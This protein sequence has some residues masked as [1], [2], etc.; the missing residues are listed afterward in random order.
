MNSVETRFAHLLQPIRDLTKNWDVD[1]ATQ[2]GEYLE[3]LDQMTISFDGGKTMMNFAE[4]A[5]LIQGSTCIY[6]RKVELLHSLVFQTLDCI[7]NKNRRRDKQGSADGVTDDTTENDLDD[8]EFDVIGEE[9]STHNVEM[10]GDPAE[11]VKIVRLPPES[12]I[13]VEA[14]E[15]Q[16]YPL[17]S[18]KGEVLG[19]CKDFR[20]NNF[21]PD[22]LGIL[23][24]GLGSSCVQFHR[25][26]SGNG[27]T[28]QD[29]AE[30]VGAVDHYENDDDCHGGEELA[31]L[32]NNDME[33]EPESDKHVERHQGHSVK[34]MLRERPTVRPVAEEPKQLQETVD[35][36]KWHDSYV[37]IGEDKR[38]K[39]GKCYN[40]PAGLDESGK[41]KRKGNSK[42]QDFWGWCT[43]SYESMDRKLKHGPF[44]PEFNYIYLDKMGQQL[45]LRKKVLRK[46]GVYLSDDVLRRT[47]LEPEN[48]EDKDEV[49][50]DPDLDGDN[51]S[52][53]EN[54]NLLEDHAP[55]DI[56]SEHDPIFTDSQM[57]RINYEDLLKKSVELFLANSQKYAQE[58]TLSR[59][60][61]EWEDEINPRL[62]AQEDR[63][64]FDIHDYGDRIVHALG[65]V[66][67]RRSFASLV[68]GM[69][70]TE[71]CRYMLASLQLANDYTVEIDKSPGL[72]ES[73]DTVHLT[74]LTEQR[75]HE[76]LKI[77]SAPLEPDLP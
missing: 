9:P 30:A 56:I 70:N 32:T 28:G 55:G 68:K 41:R 58:T 52:D 22:T 47:Y 29:R 38:L 16:K 37:H 21:T 65:A 5:L 50:R 34:R 49:V 33:V 45:K 42:L 4:A 24:L 53:H 17:L 60:V 66:G 11:P 6:G 8:C 35:P 75:A 19:S 3:E 20:I 44:Y 18:I 54:E 36:W 15:K 31:H 2:L 13:P 1:L 39:T 46:T 26:A 72:D 63:E 51:F 25:E 59:R 69:D 48:Q 27:H 10:K 67:V 64:V 74:L 73:I 7:S 76:R 57:G 43:S 12:L 40:V 77:Y 62:L 23:R 61:K 71:A 14:H